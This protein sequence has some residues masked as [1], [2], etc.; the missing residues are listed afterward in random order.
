MTTA[1][2]FQRAFEHHHVVGFEETNLVGNVYYANHLRWQGKCREM[3]LKEHC[4]SILDDLRSGL[5][6]ITV[7]CSCEYFSELFPFDELVIRMR[8]GG[9]QQNRVSML[10]DYV[11]VSGDGEELVARGEQQIAC[12]RRDGERTVPTPVPDSLRDALTPFAV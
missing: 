9:I 7:R 5:A 3:F 1:Q 4:P 11:K 8:L 10:F 6:L 2:G 12:M